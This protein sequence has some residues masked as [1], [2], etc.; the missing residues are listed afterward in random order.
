M[1]RRGVLAGIAALAAL[2]A[3]AQVRRL[4]GADIRAAR[5]VAAM[6]S[7]RVLFLGNSFTYE[8]DVPGRVAAL[9]REDGLAFAPAMLVTFSPRSGP[10]RAGI[11]HL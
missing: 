11:F 6:A 7:R 5:A 4:D 8:H 9:S 10:L 1:H 3:N 2:Q